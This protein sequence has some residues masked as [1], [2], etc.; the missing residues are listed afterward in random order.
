MFAMRNVFRKPTVAAQYRE[1]KLK[2]LLDQQWTG[3]FDTVSIVLKSH[4]T[5][6]DFLN[7]IATKGKLQLAVF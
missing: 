4:N 5:F 6:V 7:E 3:H 2:R 1:E